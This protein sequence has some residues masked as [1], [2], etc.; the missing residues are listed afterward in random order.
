MS[1][2]EEEVFNLID[3]SGGQVMVSKSNPYW[4]PAVSRMIRQK[5]LTVVRE[6]KGRGG[7]SWTIKKTPEVSERPLLFQGVGAGDW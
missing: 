3:K 6:V 4:T 5:S 2:T 1:A 7:E